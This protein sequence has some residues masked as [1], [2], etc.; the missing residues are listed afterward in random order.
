[1]LAQLAVTALKP[2]GDSVAGAAF[3]TLHLTR[4]PWKAWSPGQFVMLRPAG[5]SQEM[6]WARPFSICQ[7]SGDEL[8]VFF[9][10]RGRATS[11]MATLAPGTMLD[12]WGP[13][14][15]ALAVESNSA[16][17]LLAGGAGIAPFVGYAHAHPRPENISMEFGHRMPLHCYPFE[18]IRMIAAAEAHHER[19]DNDRAA[20]L[21]LLDERIQQFAGKGLVLA[22]G[23]V[24]FLEQVQ[25]LSLK[26]AARTQLCLETRM[27]CGIGACLGCVVKALLPARKLIN[28]HSPKDKAS[29]TA[30]A[31]AEAGYVQTCVCGPNFWADTVTLP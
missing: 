13:L 3:F 14:G 18:G 10:V 31:R 22:C 12:V 8:L 1:M 28:P 25:K 30:P 5:S 15:N 19:N 17:L 11:A 29:S 27:A 6:L 20:F 7:L 16:T 4:P 9:Q 2:L 21:L 24:P 26:Y 23:P